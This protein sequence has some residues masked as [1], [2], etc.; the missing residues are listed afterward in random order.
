MPRRSYTGSVRFLRIVSMLGLLI[1]YPACN[2]AP[3]AES[4]RD[5]AGTVTPGKRAT[6]P[7]QPAKPGR[8]PAKRVADGGNDGSALVRRSEERETVASTEPVVETPINVPAPNRSITELA[9]AVATLSDG[10]GCGPNAQRAFVVLTSTD[11]FMKAD[12]SSTLLATIE[13]GARVNGITAEGEWRLV[14]FPDATWGE[15]AAY[16]RCSVLE[17]PPFTTTDRSADPSPSV[18]VAVRPEPPSDLNVD[19]RQRRETLRGYLEWQKGSYIIVDGQRV[20]W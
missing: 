20:R 19:P 1:S 13:A 5:V 18:G 15:R 8:T 14:R 9:R 3:V 11:A 17:L 12:A 16:V 6:A 2:R 7:S 4:A 10:G